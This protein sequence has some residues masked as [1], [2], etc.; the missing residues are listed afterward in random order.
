MFEEKDLTAGALL[1][2]KERIRQIANLGY[3]L[4]GDRDQ[5]FGELSLAAACY[6]S[7]TKLYKKEEIYSPHKGVTGHMY[8]DPWPWSADSDKKDTHSRIEQLAIAGAL[9]AAEID[10]LLAQEK[11][12]EGEAN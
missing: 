4:E 2:V 11:F 1:I 8:N 12:I 6:A 9:C 10:R 5:L 7:P 3:T